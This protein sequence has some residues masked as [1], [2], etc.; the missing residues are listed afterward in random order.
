MRKPP[1]RWI[2]G[3]VLLLAILSSLA[4]MAA[5]P[6]PDAAERAANAWLKLV[7]EGKYVQSWQAASSYFRSQVTEAD[8]VGTIASL[9]QALGGL[10]ARD[11][12]SSRT[13]TSLPG[14]PDGNYVVI[15]YHTSFTNKRSAIET[16][17]MML[18]KDGRY[19]TAGYF[20]R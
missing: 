2:T 19:R 13:A 14:A 12:A 20:I 16:V 18:G 1:S 3:G 15:E 10:A 17:I 8:W 5:S 9:R 6:A 4:A 11:L 7:D